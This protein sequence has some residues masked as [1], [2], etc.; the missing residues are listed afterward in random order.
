MSHVTSGW[1]E[2]ARP[3]RETNA[4]AAYVAAVPRSLRRYWLSSL[5]LAL[6]FLPTPVSALLISLAFE[7]APGGV[8]LAG[9]GTTNATLNFGQVSA[10]EPLNPGVSRTVGA[11]SYTVSTQFGIRGSYF[12]LGGILSP[13]YTLQARL[14][15][16]HPLT[17]RVDGVTMS[18]SAATIATSLPY[19]P[20]VPH[21]LAFVVPFN[22]AAGAVTTVVEVTA[23][24]N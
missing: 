1:P 15:N 24:A 19:G 14:R 22:H 10:F 9:A 4:T 20:I 17:W 18:T 16:A 7:T 5:V 13:N 3:A 12:L 21:T 11:S 23:I 2:E 6:V 8:S